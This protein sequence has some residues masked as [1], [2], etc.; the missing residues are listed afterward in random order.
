MDWYHLK[1]HFK[2]ILAHRKI[3]FLAKIRDWTGILVLESCEMRFPKFT[4]NFGTV[5]SS[6]HFKAIQFLSHWNNNNKAKKNESYVSKL[7][8]AF[9]FR[10]AFDSAKF[11]VWI[12]CA[13]LIFFPV[14][15]ELSCQ[16]KKKRYD[17]HNETLWTTDFFQ[18]CVL[19]C[20]LFIQKSNSIFQ[21]D[22]SLTR[23][24][25]RKKKKK[26]KKKKVK[27]KRI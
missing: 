13:C 11:K 26:K 15:Y 24:L 21:T 1:I 25:L 16:K 12:I 5:S 23:L 14:F 4:D 3:M 17:R 10:C 18:F 8:R 9:V 27:K 7:P 19:S 22:S 20:I 6:M 2:N